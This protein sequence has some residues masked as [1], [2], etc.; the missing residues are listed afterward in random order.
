MSK[1]FFKSKLDSI[2]LF[3]DEMSCKN[4]SIAQTVIDNEKISIYP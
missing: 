2:L 1:Y 3:I 4:L